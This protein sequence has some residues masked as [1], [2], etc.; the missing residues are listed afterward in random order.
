MAQIRHIAF[1]SQNPFKT[2]D[3][4]REAFGFKELARF[5]YDPQKPDHAPPGSGVQL[6][7]GHLNI[8]ILKFGKDQTGVGLDY[9]GFHHFGVVV[10]DPEAWTQRLEA[11]GA[12]NITRPEDIPSSAHWEIKFRGPEGVVFDISHAEWP[13]AAKVDPESKKLPVV[14]EAAE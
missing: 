5:G 6:T 8:A 14:A 11:M 13:G 4:Y 12:P 3:F 1:A 2:A 7:D 10:D 9:A